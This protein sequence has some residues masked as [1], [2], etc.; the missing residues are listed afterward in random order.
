MSRLFA[1]A[2]AEHGAHLRALQRPHLGWVVVPG[3]TCWATQCTAIAWFEVAGTGPCGK[4][5][6][7]P[8]RHILHAVSPEPG[9]VQPTG[10]GMES[11]VQP[12][13]ARINCPL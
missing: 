4:V 11:E 2:R 5:P 10:T 3:S 9:W 8:H 6:L 12:R 7:S 1:G 13:G